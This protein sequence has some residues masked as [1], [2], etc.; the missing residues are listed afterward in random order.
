MKAA[1]IAVKDRW[2]RITD[3]AEAEALLLNGKY[4]DAKPTTVKRGDDLFALIDAAFKAWR[5]SWN[6]K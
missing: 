4:D 2:V 1:A 5:V 6:R 3:L